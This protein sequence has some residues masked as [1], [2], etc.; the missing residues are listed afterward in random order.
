MGFFVLIHISNLIT[1]LY[2]IVTEGYI[3]TANTYV[4]YSL[5][6]AIICVRKHDLPKN[7]PKIN[8]LFIRD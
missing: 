7:F 6:K 5:E 2:S 1:D 3:W 4:V 8:I